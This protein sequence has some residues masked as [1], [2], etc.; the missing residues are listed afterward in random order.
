MNK[1][2]QLGADIAKLWGRYGGAYITGMR[3]TLL[4]ALI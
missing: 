3:N 2:T 4:L 1:L